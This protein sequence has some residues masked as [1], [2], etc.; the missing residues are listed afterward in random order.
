MTPSLG[1]TYFD[2]IRRLDDAGRLAFLNSLVTATAPVFET[3][4][5]EFKGCLDNG[6]QLIGNDKIRELYGKTL[7]AFANTGG[8]V[9]VWGISAQRDSQTG[10]DAAR[11]LALAPNI[12]ELYTRLDAAE[13][14]VTN[15][16]ILGIEKFIVASTGSQGFAVCFV[17][18]SRYKP[19]QSTI[20]HYYYMRVSG[21]SV[22]ADHSSLRRLFFPEYH[23]RLELYFRSRL[24][25]RLPNA[26]RSFLGA[27]RFDQPNNGQYHLATDVYLHNGGMGTSE[28]VGILFKSPDVDRDD[29]GSHWNPSAS[30]WPGK[31]FRFL[32]TVHP[33]EMVAV[34]TLLAPIRPI[35]TREGWDWSGTVPQVL[36]H[37]FA[38]NEPPVEVSYT[39]E[40]SHLNGNQSGVSREIQ[41]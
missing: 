32:E 13:A 38:K 15:P 19:H 11:S 26:P 18:E 4:F 34:A 28:D 3:N 39:F 9:L 29:M 2:Q 35:E 20:D 10:I 7:S 16:P 22:R 12:G 41:F 23:S 30:A 21:H 31:Y 5:L 1:F 17:P 40:R 25:Q 27:A 24:V 37:L 14:N 36:V 6:G 33:H 8:G